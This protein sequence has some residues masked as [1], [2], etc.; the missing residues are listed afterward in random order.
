MT[1]RTDI[2]NVA[3]N[4]PNMDVVQLARE[5]VNSVGGDII[6]WLPQDFPG[7]TLEDKQN[8]LNDHFDTLEELCISRGNDYISSIG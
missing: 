6:V 1:S 3:L 5:L 7:E 8:A 4:T 2:L